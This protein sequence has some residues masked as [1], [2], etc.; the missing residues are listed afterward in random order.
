MPAQGTLLEG[1][2]RLLRSLGSGGMGTVWAAEDERL[3]RT[4]AI[5]QLHTP[6]ED[7]ESGFLREAQL[8][9]ALRH[10]NLVA[11]FDVVQRAT[12]TCC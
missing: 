8:G 1:R 3:G 5:K 7:G 11:V 4:V 12:R 9:A 2:Y 6:S 10:P